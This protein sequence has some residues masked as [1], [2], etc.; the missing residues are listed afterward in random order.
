MKNVPKLRFKDDNGRD[1]PAW[2]DTPFDKLAS[3][4]PGKFTVRP[5]NDPKYFGG[6]TPF[7]Q[8]GDI[9]ASGLYLKKY[10]Q[11]LNE[12]GLKV[13]KLFPVNTILITI[14]H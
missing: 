8:T 11:T 14:A 7:I 2:R 3:V 5:R 4:E 1:F 13:S 12:D 6:K 10:S 9:V